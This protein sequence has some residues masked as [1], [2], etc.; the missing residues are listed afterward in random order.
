MDHF[1]RLILIPLI[2]AQFIHLTNILENTSTTQLNSKEA[3]ESSCLRPFSV[4]KKLLSSFIN[5][6]TYIH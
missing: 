3:M 4:R 5:F 2:S 1:L 6:D